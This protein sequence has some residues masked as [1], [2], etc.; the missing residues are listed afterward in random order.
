[1]NKSNITIHERNIYETI[2]DAMMIFN[3]SLKRDSCVR[4]FGPT[5]FLDEFSTCSCGDG[6]NEVTVEGE[7]SCATDYLATAANNKCVLCNGIGATLN[8]E[9][10]CECHITIVDADNGTCT[11]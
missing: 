11:G 6:A 3:E 10:E 1:M 2:S 4:C 7:C 8:N 9:D 5:A